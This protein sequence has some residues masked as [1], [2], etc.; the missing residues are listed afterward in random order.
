M[1][2]LQVS[3]PVL[4]EDTLEPFGEPAWSLNLAAVVET[5]MRPFQ[6]NDRLQRSSVLD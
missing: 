4:R 5:G 2:L 6:R 1:Q 3:P